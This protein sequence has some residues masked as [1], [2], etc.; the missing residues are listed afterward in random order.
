MCKW[1]FG[2]KLWLLLHRKTVCLWLA[3]CAGLLLGF[4]CAVRDGPSYFSVMRLAASCR[5][6]I[7]GLCA[8]LLLPFLLAVYAASNRQIGL[9]CLI[10]GCKAFG[11]AYIGHMARGAFG[12]AGWLIQPVLQFHQICFLPVLCGFCLRYAPGKKGSLKRDALICLGILALI[13]AVAYF[14]VSPFLAGLID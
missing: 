11:F 10:C 8:S 2:K 13:A 1:G 6:S 4:L 9:I 12:S 3:F 14:V 7:V 5:M